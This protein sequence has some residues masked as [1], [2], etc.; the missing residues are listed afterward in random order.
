ME[1]IARFSDPDVAGYVFEWHPQT[2]K[3]YLIPLPTPEEESQAAAIGEKPRVQA[4]VLAEHCGT[5]SLA[6]AFVQTWCRGF[7]AGRGRLIAVVT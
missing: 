7:K 2:Q 1:R 4:A 5:H 3:V 6:Y